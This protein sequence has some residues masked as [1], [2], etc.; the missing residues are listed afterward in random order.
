VDNAMEVFEV[1]KIERNQRIRGG[2][3]RKQI[4]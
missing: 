1:V 4:L 3:R 2:F